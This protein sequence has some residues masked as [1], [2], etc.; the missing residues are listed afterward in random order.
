VV[1]PEDKAVVDIA[2]KIEQAVDTVAADKQ[3]VA[4]ADDTAVAVVVLGTVQQVVLL[5]GQFVVASSIIQ[6]YHH[7]YYHHRL[8]RQAN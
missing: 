6:L 4:E 1:T 2:A 5:L 3:A 7:L 8:V